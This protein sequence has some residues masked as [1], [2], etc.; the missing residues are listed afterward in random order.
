VP[1][2]ET[3]DPPVSKPVR[4]FRYVYT[5]GPKVPT[6]EPISA[7]P[8]P[9]DGAPPPSAFPSDL[10]ILIALLKGK[11]S[12]TD[13]PI[14]NF[15]SYDHLNPTFRQFV[16]CLSSEF[17]SG[18]IQK[19]WYLPENMLWIRGWKLVLLEELGS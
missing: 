2:T 4:D 17:I 11:R 5:H 1:P 6:S 14:L 18:L 7:N 3:T 12:C 8:S 9:V 13:Y 19:L 16:L 15:V 10:D